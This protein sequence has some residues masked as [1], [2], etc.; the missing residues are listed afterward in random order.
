MGTL[1]LGSPK[2]ED[3]HNGQNPKVS[4]GVLMVEPIGIEPTTSTLPVLRSP[5]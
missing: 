3:T 1:G 4:L 2:E 5:N